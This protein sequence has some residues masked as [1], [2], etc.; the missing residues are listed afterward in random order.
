MSWR[1]SVLMRLF[2]LGGLLLT[3]A[4]VLLGAIWPSYF[5][6][7][8]LLILP[9][10][11]ILGFLVFRPEFVSNRPK[12]GMYLAASAAIATASLLVELIGLS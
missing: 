9:A 6:I 4:A 12:L 11:F 5:T 8:A 3:G 7:V 10:P 2:F 1:G